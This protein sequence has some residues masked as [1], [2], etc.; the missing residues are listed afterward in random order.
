MGVEV[1]ADVRVDVGV[2]GLVGDWVVAADAVGDWELGGEVLGE[3]VGEGVVVLAEVP[4]ATADLVAVDDVVAADV[5]DEAGDCVAVA[6]AV[7]AGVRVA[8]NADDPVLVAEVLDTAVAVEEGLV[9]RLIGASA[10]PRYSVLSQARN[11]AVAVYN[12]VLN[13]MM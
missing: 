12:T 3:E 6:E 8:V 9:L 4:V 13:L 2:T 5:T 1:V 11:R 7:A 10:T